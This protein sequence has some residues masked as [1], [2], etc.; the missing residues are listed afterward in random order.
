MPESLDQRVRGAIQEDPRLKTVLTYILIEQEGSSLPGWTP[1]RIQ[2]MTGGDLASL[3]RH[4]IVEKVEAKVYGSDTR[5][6]IFRLTCTCKDME[7]ILSKI[8]L[9]PEIQ[10]GAV[11]HEMVPA[12]AVAGFEDLLASGV[13]M[14]DFL[15]SKINPKVEGLLHVK[16]GILLCLA[17]S[18]DIAGDRGRI[19]VL[20]Q[21]NPGTAKTMLRAW[22]ANQL[23][24]GSCSQ[25]TTKVGLMGSAA[26]GEIVP[27]ALARNDKG[28]LTI[29]E[30]DKFPRDDRQGLLEA[31]EEG[32]IEVEAGGKSKRFPAEVRVIACAN[33]IRDFSAELQDRFDFKFLLETP[34]GD[35]EKRVVSTIVRSWFRDKPW[36]DGK[37]LRMY[38]TWISDYQ[39]PISDE[40]REAAEAILLRWIELDP[41]A[42][43]EVRDLAPRGVRSRESVLR[44]AYTIARL[45]HR[46]L[47]WQ[48]IIRAIRI[49]EPSVEQETLAEL[50]RV[51]HEKEVTN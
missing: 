20:M 47:I 13:D 25:R 28:V 10:K 33:R 38:L 4:G 41:G 49:L 5:I 40:V 3:L 50:E 27:G 35:E 46:G 18:P 43:G 24:A 11:K 29:D 19:H 16:R 37:Q 31:M 14:V 30:L 39:P 42:V 1:D 2:G 48:D 17:S 44:V 23:G 7:E 45:N 21:G 9:D 51:A 32:V 6:H 34:T 36:Y 26:G 12:E 15:A 22:V 8:Y